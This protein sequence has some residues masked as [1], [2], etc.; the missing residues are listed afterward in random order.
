MAHAALRSVTA[1]RVALDAGETTARGLVEAAIDALETDEYGVLQHPMY[2][3][4]LD[5]A[6]D[7]DERI[8]AGEARPLEGVPF[9]VKDI[10]AIAG[11][12]TTYGS[13]RYQDFV[14]NVTAT[15]IRRLVD[16]GA[17]PVAKLRTYEFAAGPNDLTVNPHNP[18]RMSGGSSSGSAAAVGGGLLPFAVGTDTG[19][20]VRVP[21]AWCGA[22]GI[23]PTYGWVSRHG[24]APLSWTLD[25]VGFLAGDPMDC[26]LLLASVA[27]QDQLDPYS[28][29]NVSP[30]VKPLAEYRVGVPW[31]WFSA[32]SQPDVVARVEEAAARLAAAGLEVVDVVLEGIEEMN[33]DIV[34]H[35]IVSVEAAAVH[36]GPIHTYGPNFGNV[37]AHGRDIL[38]VDY[39]RAL[40]ARPVI[41]GVVEDAFSH[42]D[43]ML[44]PGSPI[45]AP[46]RGTQYLAVRERKYKLGNLVAR[47]TSLFDITGHPAI[48]VPFGTDSDGMPVGVQLVGRLWDDLRTVEAAS[49]LSV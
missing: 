25:H 2:E 4:A 45:T 15:V 22:V 18:T 31:G 29:D 5:A 37:L 40:R 46:E 42:V 44:T 8:A 13:P 1:A 12:P 11:V 38:G 20:S 14:P 7:S 36:E 27:G 17:I 39:A 47:C 23:K 49:L 32:V 24:V 3:S 26:L 6:A 21:A 30:P 10:I 43:L 28:A 33:V 9:G 48:T 19:G 16:A 34:K 35:V 41:Q